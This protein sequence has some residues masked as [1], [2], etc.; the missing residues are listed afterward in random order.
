MRHIYEV[1]PSY[2]N[3]ILVKF[4]VAGQHLKV[5][6][7]GFKY[8]LH[9]FRVRYVLHYTLVWTL[10]RVKR[11]VEA[12]LVIGNFHEVMRVLNY[13]ALAEYNHAVP[14]KL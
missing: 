14:V 3:L 7:E 13:H 5:V 10:D 4:N 12:Q 1:W 11:N 6:I 8:L 2:S 9:S